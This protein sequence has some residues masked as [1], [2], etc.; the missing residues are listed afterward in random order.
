MNNSLLTNIKTRKNTNEYLSVSSCKFSFVRKLYC[1]GTGQH[2]VE[3]ICIH[4][5]CTKKSV[6]ATAG[7]TASLYENCPQRYVCGIASVTSSIFL[8]PHIVSINIVDR[9][10]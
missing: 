5:L 10:I 3:C 9:K 1:P 6:V 4:T 8:P 2:A 7:F